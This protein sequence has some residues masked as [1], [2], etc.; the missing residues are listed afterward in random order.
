[1]AYWTRINDDDTRV[2]VGPIAFARKGTKVRMGMV[3][4]EVMV[5]VADFQ[6][7]DVEWEEFVEAA[8]NGEL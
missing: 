6:M 1:M 2:D 7:T 4:D 5:M 8:R 3:R